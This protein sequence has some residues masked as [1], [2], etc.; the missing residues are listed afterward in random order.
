MNDTQGVGSGV[1]TQVGFS[2]GSNPKPKDTSLPWLQSHSLR[3]SYLWFVNDIK[4]KISL[5][6]SLSFLIYSWAQESLSPQLLSHYVKSKWSL[7]VLQRQSSY[8]TFLWQHP[9][10]SSRFSFIT[11]TIKQLEI[12]EKL[13]L[14]STYPE[15]SFYYLY[16]NLSL[17][18]N[19]CILRTFIHLKNMATLTAAISLDLLYF[20]HS[21]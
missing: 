11:V 16:L 14:P 7:Q 19:R 21:G 13:M 20:C 12:L 9:S 5:F 3:S 4:G 18:W 8:F 2:E 17:K 1:L 10:F 6:F 15:I